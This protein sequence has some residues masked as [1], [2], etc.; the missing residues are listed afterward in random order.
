VSGLTST[1][2]K[3]IAWGAPTPISGLLT[4]AE[5]EVA[6]LAVWLERIVGGVPEAV[7]EFNV[8]DS[9]AFAFQMPAPSA[10]TAYRMSYGEAYGLVPIYSRT[11]VLLPKAKLSLSALPTAIRRTTALSIK[12]KLTP[13]HGGKPVVVRIEQQLP[14]KKWKLV[15]NLSVAAPKGAFATTFKFPAVGVYRVSAR[16]VST[17]RDHA[18]TATAAKKIVV[19]K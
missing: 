1:G 4:R 18:P 13:V 16:L 10:R 7:G 2:V 17:D 5:G 15:R 12:G 6:G 14:T 3:I 11:F 9:G 19:R 8:E